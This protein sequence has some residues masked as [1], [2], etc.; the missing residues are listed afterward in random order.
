MPAKVRTI[1]AALETQLKTI[2]TANG[3]MT[4]VGSVS[5]KYLKHE[6]IQAWPHLQVVFGTQ[7]KDPEAYTVTECDATFVIEVKCK[8]DGAEDQAADLAADVEAAVEL[9][10]DGKF[11]G[12]D[13]ISDVRTEVVNPVMLPDEIGRDL[14]TWGIQVN[15]T[16]KYDRGQA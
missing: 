15:V 7:E 1:K 5:E 9:V 13:F 4:D 3:Y 8:G 11:L 12:V 6:A 16:F 2:T 14:V 10:S